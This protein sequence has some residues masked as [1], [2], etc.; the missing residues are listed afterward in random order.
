MEFIIYLLM[1]TNIVHTI[2]KLLF[3]KITLP[4]RFLVPKVYLSPY[5]RCCYLVQL[6]CYDPENMC[7]YIDDVISAGV[8]VAWQIEDNNLFDPFRSTRLMCERCAFQI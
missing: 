7:S 3:H 4:Q 8:P 1:S 2:I 5:S 6:F